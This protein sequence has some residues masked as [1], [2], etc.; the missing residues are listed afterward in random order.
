MS[1]SALFRYSPGGVRLRLFRDLVLVVLF[2]VGTLVLA[3][4]LVMVEVR[5][6]LAWGQISQAT[7]Q[8]REELRRLLEPTEQQLAILRDWGRAGDLN[9]DDIEALTRRLI[10]TLTHH[11]QLSGLIIADDSGSEYFL[12]RDEARW[13]VRERAPGDKGR[14]RWHNWGSGEDDLVWQ[15]NGGYDPRRRSWF[16]DAVQAIDGGKPSWSRPYV[17]FTRKVPGITASLAWREAG[18]VRVVALDLDLSTIL[19]TIE[20]LPLAENG[21]GFL[22]RADGGIYVPPRADAEPAGGSH[23]FSAGDT[24]GGTLA[25]DA[26]DAWKNAGRPE[27]RALRFTSGEQAWWGGFS[28]LYLDDEA[29]WLGVALPLDDLVTLLQRRWQLVLAMALVVLASG[30]LLA[31]LVVRKYGRRLKELPRLSID[32]RNYRED[33]LSLIHGGESLH[34]EFKSTMRMNLRSGKVGREIELAWLKGLAAFMNTDGG[35]LLIGVEDDGNILGLEADNFEND[36]KCRLHFKNLFNQHL[37]PEFSKYV[38]FEIFDLEHKQVVA[39][40]CERARDPAFLTHR[41]GE[42][43]YIR[44]G[45]SNMELTISQAL[46]YLRR[47]F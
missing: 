25:I 13:L 16:L 37:G 17:F 28:A 27:D 39:I 36:D 30:V 12:M 35:I 33:I 5:Q 9:R 6:E 4:Y 23:F 29:A 19:G 14:L 22:F 44:S 18:S 11:S 1:L 45:P 24:Q 34:L 2:A 10:P 26:V 42:S 20:N 8:V 46:S 32:K 21:T 31:M 7:A 15:D 3:V 43:F 41:Q 40:E 47:R 38:N